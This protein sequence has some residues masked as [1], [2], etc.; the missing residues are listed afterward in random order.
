[1]PTPSPVLYSAPRAPRCSS[2]SSAVRPLRT[3]AWS[4]RPAR[5]ATRATPQASCSFSA[6]YIPAVAAATWLL[7]DRSLVAAKSSSCRLGA[8]RRLHRDDVVVGAKCRMHPMYRSTR[9]IGE[10]G[11]PSPR[12]GELLPDGRWPVRDALVG[13]SVGL[14]T[15]PTAR[16][17]AS[18]FRA[19]QRRTRCRQERQRKTSERRDA[20]MWHAS[21]GIRAVVAVSTRP[22]TRTAVP[23]SVPASSVQGGGVVVVPDVD[24]PC[25]PTSGASGRSSRWPRTPRRPGRRWVPSGP[26]GRWTARSRTGSP[27]S[28]RRWAPAAGSPRRSRSRGSRRR[29]S[30]R[31][32]RPSR[33]TVCCRPPG[34]RGTGSGRSPRRC[35]G[36]PV[37]QA[38]GVVA[39]RHGPDRPVPRPRRAR[40]DARRAARAG[41]RRRAGAGPV[42]ERVLWGNVAS[43]VAS[44]R[45]LVA[46]ARPDAAGAA[47]AVARHLLT[48]PPLGGH[49]DTARTGAARR[50]VDLPPPLLLPLLPCSRAAGCAATACSLDRPRT[51]AG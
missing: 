43:S 45:Q 34:G 22:P 3:I 29:S 13:A 4:R 2:R 42:S 15:G 50:R 14:G 38:R 44:A 40:H 17:A 41:G 39:G 6:E 19:H 23:T 18:G 11:M 24:A 12:T 30:R 47:A 31:C 51:R 49:G 36:A 21:G 27:P 5:S 8:P 35:T 28:A 32:S 9:P 37:A 25:S 16:S 1:M 10:P 33:C 7:A 48:T 20:A 26:S 46:A